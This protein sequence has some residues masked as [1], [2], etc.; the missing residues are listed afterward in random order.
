MKEYLPLIEQSE[1]FR[2]GLECG[3]GLAQFG[4]TESPFY[5]FFAEKIKDL[6]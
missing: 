6:K 5:M 1:L 3:R 2:R 4:F